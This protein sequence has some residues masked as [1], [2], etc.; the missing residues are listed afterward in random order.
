MHVETRYIL[1]FVIATA[2]AIAVRR[3]YLPYTVALVAAGLV[4]GGL[5]LFPAPHLTQELLYALVLPGLLFEAAFHLDFTDFWRNRIAISLLAVPG[6]I[7]STALVALMLAP[8]AHALHI[9]QRLRWQE[10][11]VF[12][13][14]ISATDP[15][16]VVSL[17]RSTR[18]ASRLTLLMDSESLLNDGTSIVFFTLSLALV[19]GTLVGPGQ[20]T[21]QFVAIVGMGALIGAVIGALVSLIMRRVDDPMIEIT[22]TTIAAYGSFVCAQELHYS[23]VIATVAAG[24]LCGNVGCKYGMSPSTRIAANSFWQYVAF[25]LNSIIFLLIGFSTPVSTLLADWRPILLAY[26]AV[27]ASR[28]LV[29]SL[30]CA[31]LSRTRERFPWRWTPV[32]AWGGLRGALPMVL[33]LSLPPSF[34]NRDLLVA[35]TFGVAVVSILLQGTT[36]PA[37]LR[38]LKLNGEQAQP[39]HAGGRS[40]ATQHAD[41][42]PTDRSRGSV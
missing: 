17:F 42:G 4:L 34:P 6:V 27:T 2:V 1:L 26:C 36:M 33:A 40:A 22:L 11:L 9:L 5:H 3:L 37:L 29:I 13:A 38:G 18:T 28:V 10:A 39:P 15:I 20:V 32:L 21:L 16:A 30:S 41:A 23:G 14:L 8:G 7:A 24:M 19:Q 25:A 35:M 31:L 12:G